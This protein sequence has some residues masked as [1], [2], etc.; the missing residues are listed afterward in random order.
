MLPKGCRLWD[1]TIIVRN[2]PEKATS[3]HQILPLTAALA[4]MAGP[5]LADIPTLS[6]ATTP[7][8][9]GQR[10]E[11]PAHYALPIAAFDGQTVPAR[12]VEGSLDQRAF[13]LDGSRANTLALMQPLRAQLVAAGY[14]VLFECETTGCG[15]FDFRFGM[16]VLPE[17]QMHVDLG[18]FRYLAAENGQGGVVSLLV[19]RALDQG[20]VQ[21]TSVTAGAPAP[22]APAA[23]QTKPE[24]PTK[25][26]PLNTPE[27]TPQNTEPPAPSP[28]PGSLAA[29]LE[30]TGSAALDDLV[31]ASGKAALEDGDYASLAALADWL[32]AHPDLRVTLVGHT[33]ATGSLDGNIALSKQRA[34]AVRDWLVSRLAA[35]ASQIDA[36]GAGYLAPRASNQTPEGRQKN[37]RVEVMLTST[38][39]K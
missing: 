9:I 30:L 25:A 26:E 8:Q 29:E 10:V 32:K 19:S 16:D 17:P 35:S 12:Q 11:A 13:R 4:L 34:A 33:D 38:P 1:T 20:F 18:D 5:A 2:E 31:F 14:T 39:A 28:D 36:Q 3:L 27:I 23:P 6:F 7:L 15:G 24:P 21:V 22:L 37:R